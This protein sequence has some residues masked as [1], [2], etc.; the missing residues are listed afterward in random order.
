MARQQKF[1][2]YLAEL[3]DDDRPLALSGLYRLSDL[4]RTQLNALRTVWPRMSDTRRAQLLQALNEISETSFEVDFQ[5]VAR[6]FGLNDPAPAVRRAAIEALWDA[7]DPALIKG[8]LQNLHDVDAGVRAAAASALGRFVYLAEIEELPPEDAQRVTTALFAVLDDD[9]E[10]VEVRRRA[11]EALGF[12]SDARMIPLIEAAYA[13][14]D[15]RLRASAIFA[16]GRSADE[17]WTRTV[18]SELSNENPAMRYEA[19]RAA[20]ELGARPAV[21]RLIEL[22]R[23]SDREVLE[24]AI[25]ALG[26]I[27]GA[28]A[29]HRLEKL[30]QSD[31]EEIA[32]A[33]EEALET[34]VLL[35]TGPA[36]MLEL[37][38]A[39]DADDDDEIEALLAAE[40]GE[41]TDAEL[42][43]RFDEDEDEDEDED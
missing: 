19:A 16:M 39:D 26:E 11:L 24:V 1:E 6:E 9:A 22:T 42:S 7:E 18:V 13:D 29:R 4:N 21:A 38:A 5:P 41:M 15:E 43:A 37:G 33:A 35:Q 40:R 36:L 25:W 31:D 2:D 23:D 30:A 34:L 10:I 28:T 14:P 17:R 20:G 32:E 8:F 12:S 3:L 27:G